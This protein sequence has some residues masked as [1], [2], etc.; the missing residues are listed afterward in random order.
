MN[1][2]KITTL[3]LL[4][5]SFASCKRDYAESPNKAPT[6]IA[7]TKGF[8]CDTFYT[9]GNANFE[10]GTYPFFATFNETVSWKIELIGQTS[11]ATKTIFSTSSSINSLNSGWNG[12]HDGL[13]YFEV[14]EMVTANLI[15]SGKPGITSSISFSIDAVK[16]AITASPTFM[17]VTPA[18]DF[19]IA[20][21]YPTQFSIFPVGGLYD[22]AYKIQ[23]DQIRAPQGV[24][25]LRLEGVSTEQNGFF[26]GG[27]QCRKNTTAAFNPADSTNFFPKSWTDK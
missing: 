24:Q 10:I 18:S 17:L 12:N 11:T 4:I 26:V 19:E 1:I 20:G 2:V 16:D 27:I 5:I 22:P 3:A 13:Y 9:T 8:V 15:I 21:T 14:G 7:A 23:D 6:N 25:Y